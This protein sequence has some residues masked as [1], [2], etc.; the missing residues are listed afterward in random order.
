MNDQD[1]PN[2]QKYEPRP[3]VKPPKGTKGEG[4]HSISTPVNGYVVNGKVYG[5][6]SE[7]Q[8]QID[9]KKQSG[10]NGY[11]WEFPT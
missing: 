9:Q 7:A 2:P 6:K 4:I 1:N 3:D 10:K 11:G 8:K 5:I